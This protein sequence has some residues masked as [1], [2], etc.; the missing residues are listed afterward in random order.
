MQMQ[1][2]SDIDITNHLNTL[3]EKNYSYSTIKKTYEI[4][5]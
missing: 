4:L 2:I 5:N 1:A 3:I